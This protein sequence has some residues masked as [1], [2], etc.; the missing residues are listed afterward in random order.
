MNFE[1]I[2]ILLSGIAWTITYIA[3]VYRGFK[4]K[5]YGMPLV[6]LALNFA[7]EF[8]YSLIYPPQ[9]SGPVMTINGIW[10]ICDLG[11]VATFLL[12]GFKYFEKHYSLSKGEFYTFTAIAFIASFLLMIVGGPFFKDFTP[13]F[14]GDIF[15][16]AKFIAFIQNLVMS[17]CFVSM[18]YTRRSSEGQSFTIAWSKWLGTSM[19]VGI[20]YSIAHPHNWYFIG[21]F[22]ALIFIFDVWYMVLIFQQLRR[23]NINPWQRL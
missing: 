21:I 12:F 13:Y 7:W 2:S 20:T 16:S 22:I 10:M 17:V 15:E 3:L 1:I 5:S 11:I 14:Q 4:D 18:F 6:P 8:T 19:T 23:E 9:S